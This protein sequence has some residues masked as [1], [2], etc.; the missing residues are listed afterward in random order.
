MCSNKTSCFVAYYPITLPRKVFSFHPD[1]VRVDII[2]DMV[3]G[4]IIRSYGKD[5]WGIRRAVKVLAEFSEATDIVF[6]SRSGV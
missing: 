4:M 3:S 2:H 1:I 5:L 6:G